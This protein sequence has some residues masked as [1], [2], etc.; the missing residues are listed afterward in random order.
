MLK[1]KILNITKTKKDRKFNEYPFYIK[2]ENIT[3][4]R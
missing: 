4:T 2:K 3:I 1:S